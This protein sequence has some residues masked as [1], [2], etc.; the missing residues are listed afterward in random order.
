VLLEP[1]GLH[2]EG[3]PDA[4][5]DHALSSAPPR[6]ILGCSE[7]RRA[8]PMP[9]EVAAASLVAMNVDAVDE[10]EPLAAHVRVLDRPVLD[11]PALDPCVIEG[12]FCL[13]P[14]ARLS[15]VQPLAALGPRLLGVV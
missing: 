5:G 9:L 3:E 2:P 8:H 15:A 1:G 6:I 7:Q 13:Q 4:P 14:V 11:H 12:Q 10:V